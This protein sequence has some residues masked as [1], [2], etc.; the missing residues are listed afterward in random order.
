MARVGANVALLGGNSTAWPLPDADVEAQSETRYWK[1]SPLC[2]EGAYTVS[3]GLGTLRGVDTG[4]RWFKT[5]LFSLPMANY[6]GVS[7]PWRRFLGLPSTEMTPPGYFGVTRRP[8]PTEIGPVS[9][10]IGEELH[11]LLVLGAFFLGMLPPIGAFFLY[12]LRRWSNP[13]YSFSLPL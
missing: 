2:I 1:A 8:Q 11:G 3:W 12:E 13:P 9:T 10:C 4:Q 6:P 5:A 7:I